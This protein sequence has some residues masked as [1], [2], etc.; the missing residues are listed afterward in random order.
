MIFIWVWH[1][2]PGRRGGVGGSRADRPGRPFFRFGRVASGHVGQK[3]YLMG[4]LSSFLPSGITRLS[5]ERRNDFSSFH[6]FDPLVSDLLN[7]LHL[8]CHDS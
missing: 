4:A 1:E 2:R 5:N 3:N 8:I 7:F 6:I